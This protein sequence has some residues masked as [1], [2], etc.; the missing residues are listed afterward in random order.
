MFGAFFRVVTFLL[1]ISGTANSVHFARADETIFYCLDELAGGIVFENGKWVSGNFETSRFTLKVD[2]AT[3]TPTVVI[4]EGERYPST[5]ECKGT[6]PKDSQDFLIC[7]DDHYGRSLHLNTRTLR[8]TY[9]AAS[10]FGYPSY[11]DGQSEADTSSIQAGICQR[12]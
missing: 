11:K 9:V 2:F 1:L 4:K 6:G 7:F 10:F 3:A 5:L 12:F 8:Y